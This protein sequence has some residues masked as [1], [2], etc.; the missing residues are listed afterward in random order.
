MSLW[1]MLYIF[2]YLRL[3]KKSAQ[4]NAMMPLKL[5]IQNQ[6]FFKKKVQLHFFPLLK[7]KNK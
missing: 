2:V 7:T 4:S 6:N 1:S 3:L 5:K